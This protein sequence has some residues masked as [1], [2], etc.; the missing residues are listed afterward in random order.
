MMVTMLKALEY[1]YND[2]FQRFENSISEAEFIEVRGKEAI[3]V[4]R[5]ILSMYGFPETVELSDLNYDFKINNAIDT[6]RMIQ[7]AIDE[8]QIV[9][10]NYEFM[11]DDMKKEALKQLNDYYDH[12]TIIEF[13]LNHQEITE[14]EITIHEELE[15]FLETHPYYDIDYLAYRMS[16]EYSELHMKALIETKEVLDLGGDGYFKEKFGEAVSEA[17]TQA[18]VT[19]SMFDIY[20]TPIRVINFKLDISFDELASRFINNVQA[21]DSIK[22]F[23]R[24]EGFYREVIQQGYI[25]YELDLDVDLEDY[26]EE[27]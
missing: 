15:E 14:A 23:M 26:V 9:N 18:D 7:M 27:G 21:Y 4:I 16:E 2:L 3:E 8:Q 17:M 1:E 13:K 6:D 11:S 19:A 22:A 5:S 10:G 12:N 24:D 20:N 25:Y